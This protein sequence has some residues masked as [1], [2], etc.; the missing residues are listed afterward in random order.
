MPPRPS[1]VQHVLELLEPLRLDEE[2]V[3]PLTDETMLPLLQ[4]AEK[5]LMR[6]APPSV[7]PP[8]PHCTLRNA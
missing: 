5:K 3:A 1:Q 2:S 8:Q 6:S 4:Q 7:L